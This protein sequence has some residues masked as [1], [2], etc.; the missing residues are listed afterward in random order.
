M[1][2]DL[3]LTSDWHIRESIPECRTDDFWEAQWDK[4]AQVKALQVKHNCP[5]YHGGD[6]WH[7]W[8]PSPNLISEAIKR[9]PAHFYTIAG[10]HDLPQHSLELMY[11]S[12]IYA[13]ETAG[14]LKV[15]PCCHW[16]QTPSKEPQLSKDYIPA[17][18]NNDIVER[19]VLVW[20]IMNY[21]GKK[22]WPGCTDP[23][24]AG[25]LRKHPKF[26]LI[27]TGDNHKPFV[28]EYEGRVLVNPGSL[29]RQTAAQIDHKPRVYLWS[30]ITNTVEIAYLDCKEGVVSREHIEHKEERDNRIDAF[31]SKLDGDWEAEMNFEENLKRFIS[32]ND[33]QQP[34]TKIIY[35]AIEK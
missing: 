34:I 1:K 30:G 27:L 4:V 21:Q 5:V 16:G 32:A 26:D 33:I 24:A 22:P 13:L 23:R 19:Y 35:E 18:Y 14:A 9:L 17:G 25:L 12:G 15:L 10:Q 6:L 11:K 8:K 28:E 31:I 2:V 7:H 3:I 20:H 29:T